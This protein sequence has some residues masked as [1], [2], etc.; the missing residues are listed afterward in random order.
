MQET[1]VTQRGMMVQCDSRQANV[2]VKC[3]QMRQVQSVYGKNEKRV[4]EFAENERP[5]VVVGRKRVGRGEKMKMCIMRNAG[6][7]WCMQQKWQE[8]EVDLKRVVDVSGEMQ[9]GGI[10]GRRERMQ[11]RQKMQ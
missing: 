5:S 6:S 7:T 4:P 10:C 3:T 1:E 11:C 8:K 9:N 2:P